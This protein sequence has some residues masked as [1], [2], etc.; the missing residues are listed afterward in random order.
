MQNEFEETKLAN[1]AGNRTVYHIPF[2]GIFPLENMVPFRG[3]VRVGKGPG[4][5]AL[6]RLIDGNPDVS[7]IYSIGAT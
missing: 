2:R 1:I 4:I 3:L 7:Y 5:L 6:G